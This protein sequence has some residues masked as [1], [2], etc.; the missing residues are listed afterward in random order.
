MGVLKATPK[1]T[2]TKSRYAQ[3]SEPCFCPAHVLYFV[4]VLASKDTYMY[5]YK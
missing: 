2:Q 5:N 4:D 3:V 1:P